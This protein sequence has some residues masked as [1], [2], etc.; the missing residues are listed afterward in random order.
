MRQEE[1]K[2]NRTG[3]ERKAAGIRNRDLLIRYMEEQAALG[4]FEKIDLDNLSSKQIEMILDA[5]NS[6][7][8]FR[9]LMMYYSCCMD[10]VVTKFQVMNK[11]L[12]IV[13]NRNPF[14]SIKSRLKTPISIYEK[15]QR[16]GYPFTIEGIEQNLNDV[17]GVRV[18]CSFIEDIYKLRDALLSQ[19]DVHLVQEKDYI[20][21]PKDNGYRSLHLI[22]ETPIYLTTGKKLV[23]CEVQ[24]RTIA[25]DFWASLD[26]KIK[27]KQDIPNEEAIEEEMKYS[28]EMINQLDQRMQQIHNK[29]REAK[30]K[31]Y[32]REKN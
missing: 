21:Q 13:Q 1:K 15:M 14:E 23:R 32:A 19:D 6:I 18:I 4:H 16:K 7:N 22:I 30:D 20:R 11:E 28:A 26:H 9:E 5:T 31:P 24:L 10:E 12:S 17:A 27:Y 25:M 2:N 29:I 8:E 3:N